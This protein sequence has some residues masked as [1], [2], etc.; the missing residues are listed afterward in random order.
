MSK[1]KNIHPGEVLEKEFLKS[2]DITEIKA[3]KIISYSYI[4]EIITNIKSRDD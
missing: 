1:L 4:C 2:M 3:Q